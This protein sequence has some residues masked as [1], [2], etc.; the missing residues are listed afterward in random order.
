M[1]GSAMTEMQGNHRHRFC[2]SINK[3]A[4]DRTHDAMNKTTPQILNT[5]AMNS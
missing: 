1:S 4:M 3:K 5:M 2:R